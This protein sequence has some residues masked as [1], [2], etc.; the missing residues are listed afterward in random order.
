MDITNLEFSASRSLE[1]YI[2]IR[3]RLLLAISLNA[4]NSNA[5]I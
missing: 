1:N 3:S 2:S 5:Q 4:D